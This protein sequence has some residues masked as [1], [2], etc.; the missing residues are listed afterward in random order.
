VSS[1]THSRRVPE[2]GIV[3]GKSAQGKELS[4][5]PARN[6]AARPCARRKNFISAHDTAAEIAAYG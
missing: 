4:A 6:S 3:H 1:P 2:R 5:T